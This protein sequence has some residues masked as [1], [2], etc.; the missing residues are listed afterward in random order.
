MLDEQQVPSLGLAAAMDWL[1]TARIVQWVVAAVSAAVFGLLTHYASTRVLLI[2]SV[3]AQCAP[4]RGFHLTANG[5]GC[6]CG[7]GRVAVPTRVLAGAAGAGLRP[8]GPGLWCG[9]PSVVSVAAGSRGGPGS[10]YSVVLTFYARTTS[11]GRL[12]APVLVFFFAASIWP[13]LLNNTLKAL[14]EIGT[15][16]AG[17]GRCTARG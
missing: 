8:D 2:V 13:M 6:V 5:P 12:Y 7:A 10:T 11:L 14:M 17:Q 4:R 15:R 16:V 1:A 9:R 3:R